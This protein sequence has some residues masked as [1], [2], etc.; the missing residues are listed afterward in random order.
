LHLFDLIVAANPQLRRRRRLINVL[1]HYMY[2]DCDIG[3]HA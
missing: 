2:Y 3:Q 1:L